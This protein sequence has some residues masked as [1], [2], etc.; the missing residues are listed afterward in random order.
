M[1]SWKLCQKLVEY[2]AH[3]ELEIVVFGEEPTPAYDR[4]HLTDLFSGARDEESLIL[5]R[6]EWYQEHGIELYL[7]DPVVFVDR[8]RSQVVAASGR[9]VQY[10]RLVFAT[11]S[12]PFVPPVPGTDLPGVF[13]YRT[14]EDL[15]LIEDHS[16]FST[17][18]AVVGGGLLGLEAAKALY[19]LGL[20]VHVIEHGTHLMSR[21]L[22]QRAG[23]LLKERVEELGVRVDVQKELAR[24]TQGATLSDDDAIADPDRLL[25]HFGDGDKLLVDMVVISAGI[26]PRGEIAQACGLECAKNGGIVVN[27]RLETSDPQIFAIGECASHRGMSYGLV[28]PGYQMVEVLV[29]NLLGGDATFEGTDQSAK[30]KLMGVT[31]AAL[32]EFDG[33]KKPLSS[34]LRYTTGGVYRKLVTR[35]GRLIGAVTVGDWENLDRIREVLRAPVDMSKL[36]MRRFRSTGNLWLKSESPKVSDW[37]PEALVCGCLQVNRGTLSQAQ[38]NGCSSIGELSSRTGAGTLCGSCK[39]LLADLLGVD[40]VSSLPIHMS[41]GPVSVRDRGPS[42]RRSTSPR[43]RRSIPPTMITNMPAQQVELPRGAVATFA[44]TEIEPSPSTMRSP[45]VLPEVVARSAD[46]PS[47]GSAGVPSERISGVPSERISGVPGEQSG[48]SSERISG[49]PVQRIAYLPDGDDSDRDSVPPDRDSFLPGELDSASDP[50]TSRRSWV[51]PRR[52]IQPPPG[53]LTVQPLASSTQSVTLLPVERGTMALFTASICA[54]VMILALLVW[55]APLSRT[56]V[57][58]TLWRFEFASTDGFWKQVSG[59]ALVG[60]SILT[61]TL[62]LRKRWKRF[63]FSDVPLWRMIHGVIGALSLVML[64]VHTGFRLG[65][66]LLLILMVTFVLVTTFG[67]V[68]GF[69]TVLST[70]WSPLTARDQRLLWGRVHLVLCWLLPL[71]ILLHIFQVYYF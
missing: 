57:G 8:A 21:Q 44:E 60:L 10:N 6:E 19:D 34:A 4:V 32:G 29:T 55:P 30:L 38:T 24:I 39:P 15:W 47:N 36:D 59:Y 18:A 45:S 54:V 63:A 40:E 1:A 41:M 52:S 22:D 7:D 17:R 68:A 20:K 43:S 48:V 62:S 13:V 23:E 31:V 53:R 71:L 37:P 14:L 27:D 28:L 70:E 11:G 25:L 67:A 12:S 42:S 2:R 51:P 35:K 5:A 61:L 65:R 58:G 16:V 64:M 56:M 3:E 9:E 69:I 66:H 26:R 46:E 50:L 49:T 33:D